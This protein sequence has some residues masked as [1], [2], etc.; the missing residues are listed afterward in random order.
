VIPGS[1]ALAGS[2]TIAGVGAELAAGAGALTGS[3][4]IA[5]AGAFVLP[6][7][8]A[9]N[10]TGSGTLAGAGAA[11]AAGA[12]ALTGS[13]TLAGVGAALVAGAGA[14]TG[15]GTLAGVAATTAPGAGVITGS[16]DLAGAAVVPAAGSIVGSGTIAGVSTSTPA[17]EV[18]TN[19]PPAP[20]TPSNQPA[21]SAVIRQTS[22]RFSSVLSLDDLT[23]RYLQDNYLTGFTITGSDGQPLPPKFYEDKIADAIAKLESVTHI[24]VLER[25]V[26][27]EKHD[28]HTND[29]LNYAYLQLFRTP[30]QSISQV[31][32][33]Y[34]TGQVIQVFPSEW[35]RVY[36]EHSQIHLVPTSGSLAQVMLG[37][38]NGY[39]PFIFAG[40]SYLPNLWEVD[41]VS[42][43]RVDGVPREVVSAVCKLAAIE[44]LT[45]AS[46]LVGPLGIASTSLG[47][48]G[49]SQSIA[50]QL[51][52]FKARIDQYRVDLGIPGPA[53][54]VDPKY[55]TGE[56][57]Q[58]RRTYLGMVA[59]SV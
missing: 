44:V 9:G 37:G 53:L 2:G 55:T 23:P 20:V 32:A 31:R 40:L 24:D 52:A 1:S 22:S 59:V 49:M 57:G 46:D 36:V 43:F 29:Y 50:R 19:M 27:G 21:A 13:G 5:G 17:P 39:L 26:T 12:G 51:P 54:G 16:G 30:C 25:D 10:L 33:V 3:G 35:V 48:D 47:I 18:Q 11:L 58:L 38:G 15:S 42:G 14:L 4:T 56:I 45:I 34:P 7:A 6:G 8:G 28:Y 41:Y